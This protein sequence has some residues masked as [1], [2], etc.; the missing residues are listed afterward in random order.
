[1]YNNSL[2]TFQRTLPF[3]GFKFHSQSTRSP[4]HVKLIQPPAFHLPLYKSDLNRRRRFLITRS[5]SIRQKNRQELSVLEK[6]GTIPDLRL[7]LTVFI[8]QLPEALITTRS[9]AKGVVGEGLFPF[10]TFASC[11][12]L[13]AS[14]FVQEANRRP[15]K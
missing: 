12:N 2:N 8:V 1:M 10:Q 14:N 9:D 4:S 7:N 5:G 15:C 6:W 3:K 13:R 11:V